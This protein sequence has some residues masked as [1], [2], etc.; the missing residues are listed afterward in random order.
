MANRN[1]SR[2]RTL[3]EEMTLRFLGLFVFLF[4]AVFLLDGF[5]V[6]PIPAPEGTF[7]ISPSDVQD[8]DL[9]KTDLA[10]SDYAC[11]DSDTS[12]WEFP[13]YLVE[14]DGDV[15]LLVFGVHFITRR[16]KRMGDIVIDPQVDETY[17]I[18]AFLGSYH[19]TVSGGKITG[20]QWKGFPKSTAIL[21]S[22]E[23]LF[24]TIAAAALAALDNV[25]YRK[26]RKAHT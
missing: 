4:L 24:Y 10:Y 11:L 14:Q 17:R 15:H 20:S 9:F 12:H 21:H 8:F 22:Y 1:R 16:A 7:Q 3:D 25:L 23:I 19:V 13:V 2:E 18:P 26:I 6:Y 5:V